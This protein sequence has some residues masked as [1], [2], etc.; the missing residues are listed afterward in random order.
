MTI[1]IAPS[2][3]NHRKHRPSQHQPWTWVQL[4]VEKLRKPQR[5]IILSIQKMSPGGNTRFSPGRNLS[6]GR[7]SQTSLPGAQFISAITT[8]QDEK[9][10]RDENVL[11]K[12]EGSVSAC[13]WSLRTKDSPDR[14]HFRTV[15]HGLKLYR[16]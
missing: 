15:Y 4:K 12:K 13:L 5:M 16:H 3:R 10:V 6:L 8:S 1:M 7:R 2:H 11:S 9:E 14:G